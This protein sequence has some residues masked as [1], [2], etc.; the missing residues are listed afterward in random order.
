MTDAAETPPGIAPG[1]AAAAAHED[2]VN[3]AAQAINDALGAERQQNVQSPS[4]TEDG[5]A[6]TNTPEAREHI[7][8]ALVRIQEIQQERS[9]LNAKIRSIREELKAKTGVHTKAL[10]YVLW[11]HNASEEQR[12]GLDYSYAT[13]RQAIG[14]PVQAGL[15]DDGPEKGAH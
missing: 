10:D 14:C 1:S 11:Y 9:V 12:E 4:A 7:W 8:N 15:F 6:L 2:Q 13:A 3:R 5:N